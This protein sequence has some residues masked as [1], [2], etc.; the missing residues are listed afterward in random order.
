MQI[1][2]DQNVVID[3]EKPK[4]NRREEPTLLEVGNAIRTLE[5]FYGKYA[6]NWDFSIV[7]NKKEI[8]GCPATKKVSQQ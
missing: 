6:P 7:L 2:L 5:L 4:K 1:K 3:T 8:T